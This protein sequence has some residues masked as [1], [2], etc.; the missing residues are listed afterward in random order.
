MPIVF[1]KMRV[2]RNAFDFHHVFSRHPG[3]KYREKENEKREGRRRITRCV[4]DS[5][6]K[7]SIVLFNYQSTIG[8]D[9]ESVTGALSGTPGPRARLFR[10]CEIR[11][12]LSPSSKSVSL[13]Y[14]GC[15]SWLPVNAI[16]RSPCVVVA[17]A[18]Q[19]TLAVRAVVTHFRYT[20]CATSSDLPFHL[21]A[22][23]IE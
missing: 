3:V 17:R 4:S 1:S 20:I 12:I 6:T 14:R 5:A 16:R 18:P 11:E 7:L 9:N 21:Q 8:R 10:F 19:S 2:N 13:A 23:S 15:H 22:P